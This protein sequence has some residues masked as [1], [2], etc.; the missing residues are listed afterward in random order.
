M[1]CQCLQVNLAQY[2]QSAAGD[3]WE[4]LTS[5]TKILQA[6]A[7]SIEQLS[8]SGDCVA[9][10]LRRLATEYAEKMATFNSGKAVK[11]GNA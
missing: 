1:I 4:A 6:L 7:T 11:K 8:H 10:C 9:Q 2:Y 5:F 3:A